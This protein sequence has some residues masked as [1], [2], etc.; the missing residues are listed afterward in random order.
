MLV[1]DEWAEDDL[2]AWDAGVPALEA[3]PGSLRYGSSHRII[4][5]IEIRTCTLCQLFSIS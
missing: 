1:N 3:Q 4:D 2:Q 5:C